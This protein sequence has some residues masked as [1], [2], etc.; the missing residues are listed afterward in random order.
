M[1]NKR[2]GS[3]KP[4][5]ASG[6]IGL[7]NSRIIIITSRGSTGVG[8][9]RTVET[10]ISLPKVELGMTLCDITCLFHAAMTRAGW[11][12]TVEQPSSFEYIC[13]WDE[14]PVGLALLIRLFDFSCFSSR[15]KGA[16]FS[17]VYFGLLL[18]ELKKLSS[19]F[20]R[21]SLPRLK[22]LQGGH[23]NTGKGGWLV[24]LQELY[25]AKMSLGQFPGTGECQGFTLPQ[26]LHECKCTNTRTRGG[27]VG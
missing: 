1:W 24:T 10:P 25:F 4:C 12:Q 2:N 23:V 15:F 16:H 18:L 5:G 20:I 8:G 26:C 21:I 14:A 7:Q 3:V 22:E 27:V 13:L 9:W 11:I 19:S 6:H 17:C